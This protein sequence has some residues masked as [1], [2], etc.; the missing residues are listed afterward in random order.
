MR[1]MMHYD[2]PTY[3]FV[4]SVKIHSR[5]TTPQRTRANTMHSE[6]SEAGSVTPG[7]FPPSPES[8]ATCISRSFDRVDNVVFHARDKLRMEVLACESSSEGVR[9]TASKLLSVEKFGT[10]DT[11]HT[12]PHMKL[13]YGNHCASRQTYGCLSA[14][15]IRS[16]VPQPVSPVTCSTRASLSVRRNCFVYVEFFMRAAKTSSGAGN[17]KSSD[18]SRNASGEGLGLS[19]ECTTG[20]FGN[21]FSVGLA[22]SRFPVDAEV[23]TRHVSVGLSA[24][25]C[26]SM[27]AGPNEE[28]LSTFQ[29]QSTFSSGDR[30]G[31]LVYLPGPTSGSTPHSGPPVGTV[32]EQPGASGVGST[33]SGS[34]S[35]L[36][37]IDTTVPSIRFNLNGYPVSLP[38]LA[39]YDIGDMPWDPAEEVFPTLSLQADNVA[40]W[41]GFAVDDVKYRSREDLGAPP[42]TTVYCLDGSVLIDETCV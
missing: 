6:W 2:I 16:G 11:Q 36:D 3:P 22:S 7:S 29:L 42:A 20:S 10:F 31:M 19:E 9:R 5:G 18:A 14:A 32:A 41:C 1:R 38:M 23:G 34:P 40:V 25:G 28:D 17:D 26:L 15:A 35:E 4:A 24:S 39:Q 37:I 21:T 12:S 8:R 30:V 27:C 13:S 33:D